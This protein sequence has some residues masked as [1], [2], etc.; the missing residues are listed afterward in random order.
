MEA[1]V[2]AKEEFVLGGVTACSRRMEN[3][4]DLELPE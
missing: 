1:L 4:S 3:E 2:F